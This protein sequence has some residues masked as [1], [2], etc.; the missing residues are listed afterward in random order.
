MKHHLIIV[1]FAL[2]SCQG[3]NKELTPPI[4]EELFIE[5]QMDLQIAEAAYLKNSDIPRGKKETLKEDTRIILAKH[6]LAP[7]LFDSTMSFYSQQ[8]EEMMRIYDSVLVRLERELKTLEK[9]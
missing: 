9:D 3:Q 6:Q 7:Q 4:A 8:P 1:L 2:L 5:V